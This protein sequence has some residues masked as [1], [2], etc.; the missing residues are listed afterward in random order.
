METK[1]P[2][3]DAVKQRCRGPFLFPGKKKGANQMGFF[4]EMVIDRENED[5]REDYPAQSSH[6]SE[7]F[8]DGRNDDVQQEADE[9][10]EKESSSLDEEVGYSQ[11]RS[12]DEN[13]QPAS[14]ETDDKN[15]SV[16]EAEKKAESIAGKLA[17]DS[18]RRLE[19]E[20][21]ESKRKAE[22]EANKKAREDAEKAELEKAA[23]MSDEDVMAASKKRV[24]DDTERLTR[25]N[26]KV[27]VAEHIQTR[28]QND[29]AFARQV[30]HPRKSM[31]NCF[32]YINRKAREFILQ[33]MKDND[34]DPGVF[35]G[36]DVPDDICYQ[37]AEEYFKDLD[38]EEDKVKDDK[39]VPKPYYGTTTSNKTTKKPDKKKSELNK[40]V[41]AA[42]SVKKVNEQQSLFGEQISFLDTLCPK[43]A[44]Q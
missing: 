13:L 15:D 37:W 18:Q 27:C 16:A 17:S 38:A 23:A 29:T 22:W 11:T 20:A 21:A 10:I 28:C 8:S 1:G 6:S 35:G 31:I 43:D 33:E 7:N 12:K 2:R 42:K 39:F 25:R 4:S 9:D 3:L 30:M 44:S 26:M 40:S 36:G 34:E 5:A 19:H 41:Q 32:R 24:G 14:V